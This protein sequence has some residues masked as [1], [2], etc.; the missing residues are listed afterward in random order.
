MICEK[1]ELRSDGKL[2][3]ELPFPLMVHD[4][5][6]EESSKH[7]TDNIGQ[8]LTLVLQQLSSSGRTTRVK[9]CRGQ[10]NRGWR[11]S[12]LGGA[13]GN[14][15]YLGWAPIGADPVKHLNGS[16]ESIYVRKIR[17]H[18]DHAPL[19]GGD[20]DIYQL[21]EP[22]DIYQ[23]IQKEDNALFHMPWTDEQITFIKSDAPIRV[24]RGYPGTGKTMAL[25]QTTTQGKSD[26]KKIGTRPI[27]RNRI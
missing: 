24:L 20:K 12:P 14:Q 26:L 27:C 18:D 5:F 8:K 10:E 2:K 11:R 25:W 6:I 22:K 15:Y 23:A 16:K 21:L 1:D 7:K 17:H 19:V 9:G 13:G 4:E 3:K